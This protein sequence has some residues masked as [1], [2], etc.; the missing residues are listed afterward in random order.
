M[1]PRFLVTV[2]EDLQPIPVSVRVGQ[3]VDTV[4]VAGRFHLSHLVIHFFLY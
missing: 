2:S 4:A 3:G 1:Y